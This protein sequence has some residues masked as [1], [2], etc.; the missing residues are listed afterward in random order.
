MRCPPLDARPLP[1]SPDTLPVG[2]TTQSGTFV[3]PFPRVIARPDPRLAEP[4]HDVVD[5]RDPAVSALARAL[6]ATMYALP[7]C[8]GLAAPQLG[9][10][11]RVLC[12][13]VTDH[14]NAGSCAGLVVLANPRIVHR[15]GNAVMVESC[16]SVPHP[17]EG[18]VA[19]AASVIVEGILPGS[20][21]VVRVTADGI[22]A[23]VLLHEMDHLDGQVFVD[24]MLEASR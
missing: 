19:R 2:R 4:C 17:S 11:L 8:F 18:L 14:P 10:M 20:E 5:A 23:R 1:I 24:R 16:S 3:R 12:V 6:V 9:A 22:E 13:D 7:A 15:T 21:R